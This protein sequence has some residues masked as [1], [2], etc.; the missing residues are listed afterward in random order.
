MAGADVHVIARGAHLD[1]IRARGSTLFSPGGDVV[2]PV[3]AT[4]DATEIGPR[5]V[6]F[7]V[8]SDDTEA[9]PRT[10]R[11]CAG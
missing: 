5:V 9:A 4:D 8:K 11:L 10:C 7:C 6:L 1:A 3:S 2:A